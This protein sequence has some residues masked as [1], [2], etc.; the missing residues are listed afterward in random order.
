MYLGTVRCI[1]NGVRTVELELEW[2][3]VR[4]LGVNGKIMT[5]SGAISHKTKCETSG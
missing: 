1:C 2:Y 4:L 5:T 3:L